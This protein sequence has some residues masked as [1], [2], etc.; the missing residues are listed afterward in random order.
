MKPEASQ[1]EE[2]GAEGGLGQE[3]LGQ[4]VSREVKKVPQDAK[5]AGELDEE[6]KVVLKPPQVLPEVESD[7]TKID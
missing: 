6:G 7:F 1:K 4:G 2:L 3:F 5:E